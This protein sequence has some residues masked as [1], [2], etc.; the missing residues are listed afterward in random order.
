MTTPANRRGRHA[1]VA[2]AVPVGEL[3]GRAAADPGAELALPGPAQVD[4]RTPIGWSAADTTEFPRIQ[5]PSAP[6]PVPSAES[7]L[8]DTPEETGTQQGA[9]NRLARMIAAAVSAVGLCG[10]VAGIGVATGTA[11]PALPAVPGSQLGTLTGVLA[12]RPDVI[13]QK[14]LGAPPPGR[15][16]VPVV[17]ATGSDAAGDPAGGAAGGIALD[18]EEHQRTS[19]EV[20]QFFG[21]MPNDPRVA[22]PHLD[23][24][25]QTSL[26]L[27]DF[28]TAWADVRVVRLEQLDPAPDGQVDVRVRIYR[29][30]GSVFVIRQRIGVAPGPDPRIDRVVLLSAQS[31]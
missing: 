21:S 26:S 25:M 6:A 22:Y 9:S 13:A 16:P 3:L 24:S 12:L 19:R 11:S 7:Q 23:R 31:D 1:G 10:L 2:G 29:A 14:L 17:P 15:F 5:V 30:S 18:D 27:D 28:Q 4:R 20:L 8:S